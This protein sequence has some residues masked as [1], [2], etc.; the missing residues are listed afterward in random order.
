MSDISLSENLAE[1]RLDAQGR[2]IRK[3]RD[4]QF[5]IRDFM[6]ALALCHNVTP[7]YPND[8]DKSIVEF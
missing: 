2:P 4:Q 6:T 1:T 5:I 3:R 7:T 8:D